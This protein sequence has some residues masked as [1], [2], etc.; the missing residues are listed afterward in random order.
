MAQKP[1]TVPVTSWATAVGATAE[2][3]K[4][5]WEDLLHRGLATVAGG[6]G[7]VSPLALRR[8][9]NPVQRRLAAHL[10]GFSLTENSFIVRRAGEPQSRATILNSRIAVEQV[11]H[12]FRDGWGVTDLQ[13]DLPQLTREEIEAA[14][15]YYLNH[16]EEIEED[17]RRSRDLYEANAS[18][19]ESVAP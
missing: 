9:S 15:Q 6:K 12:Y 17:M 13:R 18:K 1:S 19:Q 10:S 14:I 4:V 11:A 3:T 16:R 2:A 7:T 5:A 8:A